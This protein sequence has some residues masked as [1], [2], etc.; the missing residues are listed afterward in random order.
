MAVSFWQGQVFVWEFMKCCWYDAAW[1]NICCTAG[2]AV[3][4]YR[5]PSRLLRY[6]IR[7]LLGKCDAVTQVRDMLDYT[8]THT[9]THTHTHTV[10]VKQISHTAGDEAAQ[11]PTAAVKSD[12]VW[13]EEYW[14]NVYEMRIVYV[15]VWNLHCPH[16]HT[17]T[18]T[19]E[20]DIGKHFKIR[21]AFRYII[22]HTTTI[23]QYTAIWCLL[24]Y[25]TIVHGKCKNSV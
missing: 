5:L 20:L 13:W 22:K 9:G 19:L 23:L 1:R 3:H 15:C 7:G 8:H 11:C 10:S 25:V 6:L 14:R 17:H 16:T 18:H 21:Y 4:S 2:H 12:F 24:R